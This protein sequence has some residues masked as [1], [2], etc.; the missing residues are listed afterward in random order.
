MPLAS[1]TILRIK[2][3]SSSFCLS[4][5]SQKSVSTFAV[6]NYIESYSALC[7]YRIYIRPN[8]HTAK[9]YESEK[10]R[11]FD[12]VVILADLPFYY[13]NKSRDIK[14]MK[15]KNLPTKY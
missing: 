7:F 14:E 15:K 9:N 6:A 11:I 8:A 12:K 3:K 10:M 5:C 1:A 2:E 4:A 13:G